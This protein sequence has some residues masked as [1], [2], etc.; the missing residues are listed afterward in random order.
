M[1]HAAEPEQ[2]TSSGSILRAIYAVLQAAGEPL[3]E[4]QLAQRL[5]ERE[6][7]VWR[8]S[9]DQPLGQLLADSALFERDAAG[10]WQ[11]TV[12][13]LWRRPLESLDFVVLDSETTG[14]RPGRDRIIELGAWRLRGELLAE[15]FHS[16]INPQRPVPA[17]ITRLTGLNEQSL[18]AAP[19]IEAVLPELLCFCSEAILVGHNL[20]FD[21]HFLAYEAA[22]LKVHLPSD[23]IDVL[24]LARRLLPDQRRFGL[25]A[26]A[27]RLQVPLTAPHRALPDAEATARVFVQLLR[28]AR[29]QG[30]TTYGQLQEYLQPL[31]GK[32]ARLR[33][34]KTS[35]LGGESDQ[36]S[37]RRAGAGRQL[38][39]ARLPLSGALWLNPAWR[40]SFPAQPGV[41]LMKDG[42]GR[43]LYVGKAR[44]L[45]TRLASY[46]HHRLGVR[47]RIDSLL[48][49]VQAIETRPLG[50]ELEALLVESQLIKE[51]QPPYN[52][53]LRDYRHY[54]FLKIDVQHPFPRLLI[55]R[56]PEADGARY[57]GP[58]RS[59]RSLELTRELLQR[60]F[61]LATCSRSLPPEAAP[62]PP[63]LRYHL[64]RCLGPCSGQ[65]DSA[66]Y[67]DLI[68]EVCAFLRGERPELLERVRLQMEEAAQA[69]HY[70][71]AA[72]LRDMLEGAEEVLLCQRLISN[73]VAANNLFIVYPSAC[74]GHNEIFLIRHGRLLELQ[75]VPHA[76]QATR[77]ALRN[78]LRR[79][80]Q[81]QT[82]PA[83]VGQAEI[84]QLMI[85]SRWIKHHSRDRAFFP[86][87]RQALTEREASEELIESI[88]Q[89][90]RAQQHEPD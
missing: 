50:S 79:A 45:K 1:Q 86:F 34:Q 24:P 84:D 17:A 68:E 46:Y 43:V 4:E 56:E 40:Q 49:Q 31:E 32:P 63:C 23:G 42:E 85:I 13:S 12:W 37:E 15:S 28:L 41:Y 8:A 38:S 78:L 7:P 61:P 69:L 5:E 21:L 39:P 44:C 58:F 30:I 89:A 75:R 65:L 36:S 52:V 20:S 87:S 62:S 16:L 51:L 57:F 81:E 27:R 54:P 82:P 53:Q 83:I 60:L 35:E 66:P 19:T 2:A 73:A 3:D 11:P 80:A 59:E 76:E 72:L 70:E 25:A 22:P 9:Q 77:Q 18:A 14:L 88:W 33:M 71:R 64:G 6:E 47:P 29:Q 55:T 10:R 48:Q 90:L 74:Q 26:L 67:Q